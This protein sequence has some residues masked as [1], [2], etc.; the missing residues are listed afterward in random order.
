M[1]FISSVR[2]IQSNAISSALSHSFSKPLPSIRTSKRPPNN[3]GVALTWAGAYDDAISAL[4]RAIAL[5]SEDASSHCNLA[6]AF[7]RQ[8][9]LKEAVASY[10]TAVSSA[11]RF[12][13]A[14][15]RLG[16]TLRTLGRLQE[17]A[18]AFAT[19][20]ELKPDFTSAKRQLGG[21]LILLGRHQEGLGRLM[22]TDGTIEISIDR[23]DSFR[24]LGPD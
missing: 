3:L 22:E 1:A 10:R 19:A 6:D 24:L 2:S 4:Q 21:V 5:E 15:S 20:V 9:R 8:G 17:A 14:H 11:P 23:K 13:G 12:F 7:S 16:R 18:N